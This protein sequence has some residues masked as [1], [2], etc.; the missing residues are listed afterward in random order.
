MADVEC[1]ICINSFNFEGLRSLSCGKSQHKPFTHDLHRL[2][3]MSIARHALSRSSKLRFS[4]VPS[5]DS[6]L[7]PSTLGGYLSHLPATINRQHK[8][9]LAQLRKTALSSRQPTSRLDL[10]KWTPT[11]QLRA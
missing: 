11:L 5:A 10:E 1:P 7:N 3:G 6:V 8:Q 9:L 4:N 2:Q